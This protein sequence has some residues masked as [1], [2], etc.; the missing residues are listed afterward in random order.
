MSRVLCSLP[1]ELTSDMSWLE[2]PKHFAAMNITESLHG[3]IMRYHGA[4]MRMLDRCHASQ[5][6][7]DLRR[8]FRQ[9]AAALRLQGWALHPP[10]N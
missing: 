8:A 5:Q 7:G 4:V 1:W 6:R 3:R 9:Y 2:S 10:A